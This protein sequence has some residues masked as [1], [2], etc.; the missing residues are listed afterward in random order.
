MEDPRAGGD[1][2]PPSF[3]AI[4]SLP[5]G[6]V[7]LS[8]FPA[9]S[10]KKP[11]QIA[12]CFLLISCLLLETEQRES[13]LA[14]SRNLPR[15]TFPTYARPAQGSDSDL[16]VLNGLHLTPGLDRKKGAAV[17]PYNPGEPTRNWEL[18]RWDK[19]QMPLLVWISPG[20]KLPEA[21][22]DVL[23]ETRV[24]LVSGMMSHLDSIA[25]LPT[26][27]GWTTEVNDMVAAGFEQW[28]EMENEGVVSF[29]F[30]DDPR[31]A[32]IVVFFT[33]HFV[34][35]AGP[36]GTNV[37][38]LTCGT[39][40]PA[41]A[42][43][44][45]EQQGLPRPANTL[46]PIVIELC[47]NSDLSKMQADAAHEFGHA[48]GIKDHSPYRDDIMYVNRIVDTLSPADKATLRFLYRSTPKWLY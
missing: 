30:V 17:A 38:G 2:C 6:L 34:G 44:L 5:S 29:G 46:T 3:K 12:R 22:F 19:K 35:A 33:D 32:N 25:A 15:A 21:P 31:K 45:N 23:P 39:I 11:S 1:A 40:Y 14:Q 24:G 9:I 13:A 41:Q 20:Q 4:E 28:R 43:W 10:M 27:P 36:G 18:V 7:R 16:P 47:V 42:L 48:L 26:A 37:H 8:I